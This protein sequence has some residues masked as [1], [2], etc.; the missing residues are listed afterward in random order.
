[1]LPEQPD[2][3]L[4]VVRLWREAP[5]DLLLT[6]IHMPDK[7]GIETILELRALSP[8]LPI[9]AVS[10]SGERKCRD[11]LKDANLAG[12]IRTLDKPFR[13]SEVLECVS[14]VLQSAGWREGRA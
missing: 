3:L 14:E 12:T 2:N 8:S 6:D 5:G 11:L 10:G 1:M 9:V 7:D 13:L 4:L